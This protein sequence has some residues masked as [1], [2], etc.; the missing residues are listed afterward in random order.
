MVTTDPNSDSALDFDDAALALY[1][2]RLMELN[3]AATTPRRLAQPDGSARRRSRLCGST[4]TV[5]IAL[6]PE[7][8]R[9]AEI[10]FAV[11]ACSL[12]TAATAIL[13]QNGAGAD[14]DALTKMRDGVKDYLAGAS[15]LADLPDWNDIATLAPARD[16]KPR[17]RAVEIPFEAAVEAMERALAARAHLS[18]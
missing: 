12:G 8:E 16:V 3:K 6:T 13:A 7:G 18:G 11:Q 9:V 17:H 5:D 2:E 1:T 10:G 15:P 4:V 14:L